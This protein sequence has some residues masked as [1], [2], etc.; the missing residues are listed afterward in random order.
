MLIPDAARQVVASSAVHLRELADDL[1]GLLRPGLA[2]LARPGHFDPAP[3]PSPRRVLL[4][5]CAY[6]GDGLW[7]SQVVPALRA[8][9]P[10]ARLGVVTR[11]RASGLWSAADEVLTVEHVV[12]D[13]RREPFS[14]AGFA[15]EAAR[16]ARF[17]PDLAADLT[18][19]RYT[20]LFT[21]LTRPRWSL[22]FG[23]DE[24][25][26]LYS[27]RVHPPEGCHL[28]ERPWWV[29]EPALG[30][31]PAPLVLA[32]PPGPNPARAREAQGLDPRGPLA[33]LAPGSGW[34]GKCW[35]VERLAELGG[36]LEARGLQV[37][38]LGGP[39][40]LA[41]C[42]A[43]LRACRDG[44][45]LL[46]LPLPTLA[47]IAG[48]ARLFVGMDSG[49]THLAAAAG[50]PTLALFSSTNPGRSRPLG[51]RVRVLRAGCPHRPEGPAQDCH[52]R[53]AWPCPPSCW[54]DLPTDTVEAA[55]LE[56]L[57]A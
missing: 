1:L 23:G 32:P 29:L 41:L 31:P 12:S 42:R 46:G 56:L 33:V 27:R 52:G 21:F 47:A 20:A 10:E 4:V 30:P 14:W 48:S 44:R 24:L 40:D 28:A 54:D 57:G 51:P 26:R 3:P 36:R 34:A 6:M 16:A 11:A 49:P 22:G 25:G 13:R 50:A 2:G 9:W 45:L 39:G 53:P 38:A 8:R 7:A 5:S 37:T 15:A 35:P 18:G 17:E 43:A 55:A 19:N